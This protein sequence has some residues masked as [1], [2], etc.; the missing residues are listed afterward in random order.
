[1]YDDW[2]ER[3]WSRR[4]VKGF[5]WLA[6]FTAAA[7]WCY[8][9]E[10]R[11]TAR[12]RVAIVRDAAQS[13]G[14]RRVAADQLERADA[15]I[16]P[17]LIEELRSGDVLGR[18]LAALALGRLRSKAANAVEPLLQAANDDQT[19]VRKQAVIAL[20]RIDA[21]PQLGLAVLRKS[22]HDAD[23]S[24][25]DEAFA[26]LGRRY[27]AGGEELV[28]LLADDDADVR[29]RAAIELGQMGF[30]TN[31]AKEALHKGLADSDPRVRA[32]S[33]ATLFRLAA[34]DADELARGM[35]DD[36]DSLVRRT[37]L[38]LLAK[39]S[40]KTATREAVHQWAFSLAREISDHGPHG[41]FI[42]AA[43]HG[44]LEVQFVAL[45]QLIEMG[46]S[47][48][49]VR[50]LT[51]LL[52]SDDNETVRQAARL[53]AYV[54]LPARRSA[55][56]LLAQFDA[57][58][59]HVHEDIWIALNSVGFESR[60]RPPELFD[61]LHADGDAAV[62]FVHWGPR[63]R[64]P[65]SRGE[66]PKEDPRDYPLT[67][68]DMEHLKRLRR[69]EYLFL[70]GNPIGD[71]GLAQ[72]AELK[73]LKWLD[74][75]DTNVTT[76]GLRH[77]VEL[78][79]LRELNLGRCDISDEGLKHLAQLHS[80]KVLSL[81][82]T[83]VTDDGLAHLTGL[84][85]L[86]EVRLPEHATLFGVARLSGLTK[87]EGLPQSVTDADLEPLQ[88]LTRLRHLDLARASVTDA[89][90]VHLKP[91]TNLRTLSLVGTKVTQP[92]VEQLR[93]ALPDLVV[94]GFPV[95]ARGAKTPPAQFPASVYE[96]VGL[97]SIV[98][99]Q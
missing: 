52:E 91:L 3:R 38:L 94:Y 89:G 76:A 9:H 92:A 58:D 18:E 64:L 17:E 78:T 71:A 29:R 84:T 14:A 44:Q 32:E 25:R 97:K 40:D 28:A 51:A 20:G 53:L 48:V 46:E 70:A 7:C 75:R 56:A 10:P 15:S 93:A 86:E 90:L 16:V 63:P 81:Y 13:V 26:A 33:Y 34:I 42:R 65:A 85:S 88:A 11:V 60:L 99:A 1:M 36:S 47:D 30:D 45:R 50:A 19:S 68:A 27:S 74:L 4:V 31:E 55:A 35:M 83:Q 87:I 12:Q 21:Q 98:N 72:L 57:R 37:A 73:E 54:G 82:G 77:L 8:R 96:V 23:S 66:P 67:D 95:M 2:E 80:L 41:P 59:D 39:H 79:R 62:S 43:K 24:I 22:A 69:L 5:V 61:A 49:A 6:I